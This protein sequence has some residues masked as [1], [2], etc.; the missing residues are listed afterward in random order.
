MKSALITSSPVGHLDT[1]TMLKYAEIDKRGS[2]VEKAF[3]EVT[4][5]FS[6]FIMIQQ[7]DWTKRLSGLLIER[8]SSTISGHFTGHMIW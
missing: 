6:F 4:E 7:I 2:T 5:S 8:Y 3:L 1:I